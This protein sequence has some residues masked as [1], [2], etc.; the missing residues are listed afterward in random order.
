VDP[1][2][3]FTYHVIDGAT[4]APIEGA[5]INDVV[6]T[7]PCPGWPNTGSCTSGNGFTIT[8][9]TDSNGDFS[10][11]TQFTCPMT[12]QVKVSAVGFN[13]T[14]VNASTGNISGNAGVPDTAIQLTPL[15]NVSQGNQGIVGSGVAGAGASAQAQ[16]ETLTNF[17]GEFTGL[18]GDLLIVG[19]IITII[20]IAVILAVA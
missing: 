4:G 3:D 5:E 20:A 8:G 10:A 15:A 6:N 2:A 19:V 11:N 14:A 12:H 18:K 7:S 16:N 13:P 17:M 1:T 9:N